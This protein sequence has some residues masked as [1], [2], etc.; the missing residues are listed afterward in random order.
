[1]VEEELKPDIE[2]GDMDLKAEE[3]AVEDAVS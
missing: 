3:D 1:M 2:E